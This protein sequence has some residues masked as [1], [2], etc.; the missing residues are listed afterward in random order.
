MHRI[1]RKIIVYSLILLLIP[2]IVLVL[3]QKNLIFHPQEDQGGRPRIPYEELSVTTSDGLNVRAWWLPQT[4]PAQHPTLHY[5]HGNGGTLSSLTHV[6]ELFH[7]YGFN[8]LLYDYR[9]YGES[10]AAPLSEHAVSL[11]A[12]ATYDWLKQQVPEKHIVIW[13]HSLG[14]SVAARLVSNNNPAGAILEGAFPSMTDAARAHYPFAW[15]KE[16]MLFDRFDTARYLKDH[17]MPLLLIHAELDSIIPL[18]LGQKLFRSLPPTKELI[19][20]P[21]IDHNDFPLVAEQYR[22]LIRKRTSEWT[23]L[24]IAE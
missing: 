20:I 17:R 12:Q 18:S 4:D 16:W 3:N 8:T 24:P 23:H 19:V 21:G 5:S 9:G 22:D 10:Q 1:F 13:G 7:A 6:A 2:H 14:S 15:I 11:D